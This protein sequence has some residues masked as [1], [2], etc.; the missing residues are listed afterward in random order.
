MLP[1]ER[2]VDLAKERKSARV[3][4]FPRRIVPCIGHESKEKDT[5]SDV[6]AY[7]REE[8]LTY[9][10]RVRKEND[11]PPDSHSIMFI[12]KSHIDNIV[13]NACYSHF[14]LRLSTKTNYTNY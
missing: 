6:T 9:D 2:H 14:T 7:E 5:L 10:S 11:V 1:A 13:T 12:A 3:N 8:S 4:S